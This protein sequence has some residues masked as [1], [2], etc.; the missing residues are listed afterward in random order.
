MSSRSA[1]P[2]LQSPF[3]E[4]FNTN[5]IPTDAEIEQIRAHLVPHEAELARLEALIQELTAQRDQVKDY[6][7]PHQ[8]LISHARRIPQDIVEE[9]FWNCLPT[10]HNAIMSAVEAPLLLGRICS[11]WRSIALSM[12]KLWTSLHIATAFVTSSEGKHAAMVAW[13]ERSAPRPLTLSVM[14]QG[15]WQHADSDTLDIPT[16][17]LPFSSR[18]GVLHIS[19]IR[20]ESLAKLVNVHAP[21]LTEIQLTFVDQPFMDPLEDIQSRFL[22]SNIFR[23]MKTGRIT[24]S[25]PGVGVLVPSMPFTWDHITYLSLDLD[26]RYGWMESGID[27]GTIYRLLKGCKYLISLRTSMTR[28]FGEQDNICGRRC[29]VSGIPDI[30][31]LAGFSY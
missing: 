20:L 14:G 10:G 27:T 15:M 8:A 5:Y 2:S 9:V 22:S 23:S 31:Q 26:A 18:L 4:H 29:R 28:S 24:I 25:G 19:N 30:P 3:S 17:L 21:S 1:G 6:I 7:E 13:L 11:A 12:P 16:S